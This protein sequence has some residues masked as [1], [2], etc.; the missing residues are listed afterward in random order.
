MNN[1]AYI[2]SQNNTLNVFVNGKPYSVLSTDKNYQGILKVLNETPV[3]VK[4]LMSLLDIATTI[5]RSLKDSNVEVKNGQLFYNG[6]VLN[7]SLASRIVNLVKLGNPANSLIKF[8]KNLMSNPSSQSVTE[9][10]EFLEHQGL[11]IDQDG[12]VVGYKVVRN[13]YRDKYTGTIDNSV[14]K[15]VEFVRNR[16]DDN[17]DRTCS[18]GLH[19]G[20]LSYIKWYGNGNDRVMIVRFNP[21]DAVSVPSDHNA[22][23][24]RVCKYEVIGELGLYC[25][26]D[27]LNQ[28]DNDFYGTCDYD[29]DYDEDY[30]DYESYETSYY[31]VRDSKGRFTRRQ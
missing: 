19:I 4:S 1:V 15:T 27:E 25:E 28:L 14:G 22:Q 31:N 23:K 12:Y 18:H 17:R 26:V 9:L 30:N 11:P 16:V 3:N 10:Y 2:I 21:A 7:N 13:D 24:L 5:N 29:N 20:T 8:L 6:E